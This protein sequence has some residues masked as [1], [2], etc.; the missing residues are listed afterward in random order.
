MDIA[1]WI[2][3]GLLAFAYIT[4]GIMKSFRPQEKLASLPWTQE[5]S[6]GTVKFIGA[7][8]LLGGIG[9]VLPWLTGTAAVLTPVAA[10]GL[11]VVQLLA[12]LHHIR[13]HEVKSLPINAVLLLAALFIAV[14]R[15]AQL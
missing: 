5:Y 6:A 2:A 1:L 11:V 7:A 14:G 9:L 4:A 15:F 10:V 3:S 8:E 12:M 13:H